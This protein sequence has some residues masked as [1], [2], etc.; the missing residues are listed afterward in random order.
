[1]LMPFASVPLAMGGEGTLGR[2]IEIA[3]FGA[4]ET[5]G[6]YTCLSC[7]VSYEV[8]YHVCPECGGYSVEVTHE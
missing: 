5:A 3:G 8:Q 1:M 7:G 6:Q 2:L 4:Q